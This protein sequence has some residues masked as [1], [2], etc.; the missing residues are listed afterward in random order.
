MKRV[1]LLVFILLF[2]LSACQVPSND[3]Q[4]TELETIAT[5]PTIV[6]STVTATIDPPEAL[7]ICTADLPESLFLYDEVLTAAKENILAVLL[8]GPFD[9]VDGEIVPVILEK[10]PRANRGG[11]PWRI[12]CPLPWG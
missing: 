12:S 5:S 8:D 11:C 2:V 3:A 7:T 10:V 6:F 9:R 4:A 1:L